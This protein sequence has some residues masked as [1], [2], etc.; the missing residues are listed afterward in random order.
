MN[1]DQ[2]AKIAR[3]VYRKVNN[4]EISCKLTYMLSNGVKGSITGSFP[5]W[6]WNAGWE[7]VSAQKTIPCWDQYDGMFEQFIGPFHLV[8]EVPKGFAGTMTYKA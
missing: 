4:Q 5:R 2:I 6:Q 7:G 1:K 3:K 8:I